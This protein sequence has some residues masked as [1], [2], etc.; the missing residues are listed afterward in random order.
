MKKKLF[1]FLLAAS[2]LFLSSP[3]FAQ[4]HVIDNAGLLSSGEIQ[5]LERLIS[6]IASTYNFD[7]VILTEKNIGSTRPMDYADDYFDNNGYGLGAN[8]DGCLFLHVTQSRD[9]WFSTSGRGSG[10]LKAD[11]FKRLENDVIRFLRA[12]DP[13]GAYR[14]FIRDWEGFLSPNA[15]GGEG[16]LAPNARGKSDNVITR[17]AP[18]FYALSWVI[19]L[20]IGLLAVML[21]KAKMSNVRPKTEADSF[22][23]PGSLVFT[24]RQDAFLYSTVTKSERKQSSSSSSLSSS[25]GSSHTSSSG[26]SHGGGGGKY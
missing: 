26:S 16:S 12:D 19:S 11:A 17:N 9:Y 20:I 7:L 23:V 8:R 10:I 22:I 18:V 25:S 15:N 3:L 24:Q 6:A 21:M 13:A 14:V 5:E 1:V 4:R 2:F